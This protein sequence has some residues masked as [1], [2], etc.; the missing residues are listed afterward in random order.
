MKHTPGPWTASEPNGRGEG[1]KVGPAWLGE[2]TRSERSA[3]DALLIASAPALL[4]ALQE[5]RYACTDKAFAMADA[6]I[7][8]A[9]GEQP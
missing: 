5:L 3:A 8:K 1:W 7:A 9:T 6:A 4:E 2:A